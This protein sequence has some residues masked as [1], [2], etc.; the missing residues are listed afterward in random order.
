MIEVVTFTSALTDSR[1]HRQTRVLFRNVVDEFHHV[2]GFSNTR[3][4]EESDLTALSKW[5]DK[6]DHLNTGFKQIHRWG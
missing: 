1:K 2:H 5:A 6:I 3:A 4:S